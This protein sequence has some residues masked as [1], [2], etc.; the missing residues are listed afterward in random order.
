MTPNGS[1]IGHHRSNNGVVDPDPRVRLLT[2]H[3]AP[4][5]VANRGTL[6]RYGWYRG[7]KI[8][9]ADQNQ[10]TQIATDPEWAAD[11]IWSS[12]KGVVASGH[13]ILVHIKTKKEK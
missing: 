7:N 12:E 2:L 3:R 13:R 11:Y 5:R 1:P 6:S 8:L 10:Q 4:P 9:G